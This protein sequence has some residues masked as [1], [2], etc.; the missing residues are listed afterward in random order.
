MRL[1]WADNSTNEQGFLIEWRWGT[2]PYTTVAQVGPNTVTYFHRDNMAAGRVYTY[3]VRAYSGTQFS[4]SSNE[5]SSTDR[6]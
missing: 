4:A 6:P 3:R 2:Q 1:D 5:S